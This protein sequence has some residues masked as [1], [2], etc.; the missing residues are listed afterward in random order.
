MRFFMYLPWIYTKG[1]IERSIIDLLAHSKHDW[2]ICT[3]YFDREAT[4]PE[5]KELPVIEL[6]RISIDRNIPSVLMAGLIIASQQLPLDDSYDGLVIWADGMGDAVLLNN[7]SHPVLNFCHTPL[8]PVFDPVYK[9]IAL[10]KRKFFHKLAYIVFE[11]AFRIVDRFFWKRMDTVVANSKEVANRIAAGGLR[12]KER[13]TIAHPGVDVQKVQQLNDCRINYR[14]FI[15]I[16]GRIA[17]TKNIELALKAFLAANLGTEWRLIITGFVD[18][19]SEIYFKSLQE[20]IGDNRTVKLI[21]NPN[22]IAL[23][24]LYLN[25]SFVLFPP[26][27]EDWGIVPLE[28]MARGKAVIANNQ[29][30]PCESIIH[31]K[32]GMLLDEPSIETWSHAIKML[33]LDPALVRTLGENALHHANNFSTQKFAAIL[34]DQLEQMVIASKKN[35][36]K[37]Q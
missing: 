6:K 19:K 11:H 37:A 24:A 15:L 25:A 7:C 16:A 21:R 26:L 14:R 31:M 23:N 18:A 32:T 22:D 9:K 2:Q 12:S 36:N 33:A 20:I 1:G 35:K 29:G 5:F 17:W 8:R 30:G 13:I 3:N 27:N 34:D 28:S 10:S 4:F